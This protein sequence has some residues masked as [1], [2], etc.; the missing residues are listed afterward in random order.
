MNLLSVC[1]LA[2][3]RMNRLFMPE[4]WVWL[5]QAKLGLEKAVGESP[6]KLLISWLCKELIR[7]VLIYLFKY[8]TS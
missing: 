5:W 1:K 7:A 6:F 2:R 4:A 8:F 3:L